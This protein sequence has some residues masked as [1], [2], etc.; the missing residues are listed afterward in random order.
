MDYWCS[1]LVVAIAAFS[2]GATGAGLEDIDHVVLFMQENRAF[3]HYY[4][5]MAGVRGFKDP[6]VANG[7][8]GKPVWYQPTDE[9]PTGYL[10]P[11]WL[12]EDS[13]Y[14]ESNQC[15]TGG[16]SNGWESNHLAWN[17]GYNDGWHD[18]ASAYTW[19]H[20]RR[21]DI[22]Y[23]FN[24]TET[25]TIADMYAESVIGSTSP[26]RIV[27]SSGTINSPG[28]LPGNY[29]STSGFAIDNSE[30]NGCETSNGIKYSCYPYTWKTTPEYLEEAGIDWFVFQN[31]DNFDDN[32][33]AWFEQ[34]QNDSAPAVNDKA[35]SFTGLDAFFDRARNGS[36]P[37][38]SYIIGQKEL[39]EHP[40]WMPNDGAWLQNQVIAAVANSPQ[41]SK[42][43]LLIS[44]D[45]TG[46]W[47]D[48][49]VPFT[50]PNGTDG[51]EWVVDPFR[52]DA[53]PVPWG[54]GFRVPFYVISPWT[55][56]ANV[57]TEPA[58]HTS[59]IMFLEEWARAK[60]GKDITHANISPW[61]RQHM[62]NLV[63]VFDFGNPDTSVPALL[64]APEPANTGLQD[65]WTGTTL[66]QAKYLNR[67]PPVP[68]G[69]QNE[70]S[71]LWT[72]TGYKAVRG[73]LTEG[74]YLVFEADD[75][76]CLVHSGNKLDL[77]SCGDGYSS[78]G[79]RFVVHQVND[80][81]S[82]QFTLQQATTEAKY[83]GHNLSFV[84][85]SDAQ[86]FTI[87]Y[88]NGRYETSIHTRGLPASYR[89]FAVTY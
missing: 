73:A 9:S 39:S 38:V 55:R 43:A 67:N 33:Y 31:E 59:Q 22:P 23:H 68:Y 78:A 56:G 37:A 24:Y 30:V 40:P 62:S 72:E 6:N 4:G 27:W 81:F 10:L 32:P 14:A 46:G 86:Q 58:D 16:V 18:H 61:R 42:T 75:G 79:A 44:Y 57:F 51:G 70:T 19:G 87:T 36:L 48:H 50:S 41:Y 89:V 11:F 74:R 54:P 82:S 35:N 3:D 25:W 15:M 7:S 53:G 29:E 84:D 52:P 64:G 34:Y 65:S 1:V 76:R 21:S 2:H 13:S 77:G 71:S 47:G 26:N 66:C 20:F 63:N 69:E 45:E 85:S 12:S 88:T 80:A 60:Y 5:T 28:A 83:I 8:T 49:V 17:N